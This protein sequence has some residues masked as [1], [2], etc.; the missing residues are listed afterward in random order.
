MSTYQIPGST[1]P[2]DDNRAW[3]YA[4]QMLEH[5]DTLAGTDMFR[6][7]NLVVANARM[8]MHQLRWWLVV[9]AATIG[10]AATIPFAVT[11]VNAGL[12]VGKVAALILFVAVASLAAWL[13]LYRIVRYFV[14]RS[15]AR[16]VR[17]LEAN[18]SFDAEAEGARLLARMQADRVNIPAEIKAKLGTRI[19]SGPQAGAE[20][21]KPAETGER[22]WESGRR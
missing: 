16:K 14:R 22:D 8:R 17:K 9:V 19:L 7:I 15:E 21:E 10:V 4:A 18:P 13:L 2:R 5:P 6:S 3:V 20:P 1:G 12:N 11:A